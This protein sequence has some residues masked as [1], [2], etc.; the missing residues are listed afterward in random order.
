MTPPVDAIAQ[1]DVPRRILVI[2]GDLNSHSGYAR[3]I[4]LYL[5]LL[6]PDFDIVLGV[7]IHA[8]P[9]RHVAVWPYP[10]IDD[11]MLAKVVRRSDSHVFVLTVSTPNNFRSFIGAK[12]VGL[13]FWE[14]TRLGNERWMTSMRRVDEVWVPVPFM[15]TMLRDEGLLTPV[16]C[17]PCPLPVPGRPDRPAHDAAAAPPELALREISL[18]PAAR[19]ALT[20]LAAVRAAC[21]VLFLSVNSFIPRK[22]FPVLAD[23]WFDLLRTHPS[24]ALV[25]KAT[26]IDAHETPAQ[27]LT[28]LEHLFQQ[29]ARRYALPSSRVFVATGAL[30]QSTMQALSATCDS[31]VTLS[32]GEGLGL[33]LFETLLAGKPVI[34]PRHTSFADFLPAA[35]PYFVETELANVGLADPVGVNPISAPWGVPREGALTAAVGRLLADRAAGRLAGV[36]DDAVDHFRA[37]CRPDELEGAL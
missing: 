29:V 15:R 27:L 35:Y 21:S 23:S 24:A 10:L 19:G 22:G 28:R 5:T 32:F 3:A 17:I 16:R 1:R 12:C 7:D 4:S 6:E 26:S 37:A 14:T 25:I 18:V 9:D 33:G 30:P 8:Q 31:F 13:F 20:T 2:R 34:C 36:L 11:F